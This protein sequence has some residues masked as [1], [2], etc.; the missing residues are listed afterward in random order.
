M[1]CSHM[2]NNRMKSFDMAIQA[3]EKQIKLKECIEK[4]KSQDFECFETDRNG[5][6]EVLNVFLLDWE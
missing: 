5:M 6:I 2:D 4:L 3:L 1:Q